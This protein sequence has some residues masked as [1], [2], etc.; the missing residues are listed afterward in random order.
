MIPEVIGIETRDEE[1]LDDLI[2]WAVMGATVAKNNH[3]QVAN[4]V[5]GTLTLNGKECRG[6]HLDTLSDYSYLIAPLA[7]KLYGTEEAWKKTLSQEL[8]PSKVACGNNGELN[9]LGSLVVQVMGDNGE[10]FNHRFYILPS[11]PAKVYGIVGADLMKKLD[12]ELR[13]VPVGRV[14]SSLLAPLL[15]LAIGETGQTREVSAEVDLNHSLTKCCRELNLVNKKDNKYKDL[16]YTYRLRLTEELEAQ[17]QVNAQLTGFCTHEKAEIRFETT[18]EHPVRSHPYTIPHKLREHADAYFEEQLKLGI[19]EPE[20]ALDH[21]LLSVLIVPKRDISGEVK[22]WRPC[23]DP[24]K[25]NLKISNPV[26]PL[27]LADD[28]FA[29]VKGKKVTSVFDL[30][31]GF[32]QMR[33]RPEDR[34]KTA[35]QWKGK[36]YHFVGAPFGFKN[37]PQDFQQIMDWIFRDLPF[38]QIYIDD[39]IIS[40]SSFVEHISHTKQVLERLTSVNLRVNRKKCMI[41]HD[42]MVI[43]GNVLSEEGQQVAVGKLLKMESWTNP[44][45]LKMLQRQLGFLNYFRGYVCALLLSYYGTNRETQG[46]R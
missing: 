38:V 8:P 23:L 18:D 25:I 14:D 5:T 12:I 11:F 4:R 16:L 40:S 28:I 41:A 45:N 15:A 13:N 10:K 34:K 17:F 27:P 7:T 46:K 1:H 31:A 39:I 22:G 30:T 44:T 21:S 24:R 35:F 6:L 36:V 43:L 29:A 3:H 37:I 20:T 2:D 19:I 42:R 33:V 9:M 32:N 26:Y